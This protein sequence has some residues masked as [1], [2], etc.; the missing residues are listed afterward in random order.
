M[1]TLEHLI[2]ALSLA[3][4][5]ER[6]NIK[7][8]PFVGAIVVDEN[9]CIIG[10]GYHKMWGDKHAEVYAIEEAK[11]HTPDLTK[12]SLYVTLEPCSHHG[13]T[14]PCTDLIVQ[15]GI[16]TVFVGSLDPNPKVSGFELLKEKGVDIQLLEIKEALELNKVFFTNQKKQRPFVR[17]KIAATIA[18]K[19]ADYEANSKWITNIKSRAYVH[20]NIRTEVDAVLSTA[21]T[22]IEDKATLNIRN[23]N[24]PSI[25]LN[26][27][28]IDRTGS[29]LDVQH[30]T[31]PIFYQ[32]IHTKVFIVTAPNTIA[33][34]TPLPS[35][36][37]MIETPFNSNKEIDVSILGKQLLE[38]GLYSILV[39]AGEIF[40][41]FLLTKKWVD[42][43]DYFIGSKTL[44]DNQAVTESAVSKNIVLDQKLPLTL[45]RTI[46]FD[47]DIYLHYAIENF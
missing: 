10:T 34:N 19:M 38:K 17:I 27:V 5:A 3:K 35:N 16:K 31:L 11:S 30:A 18:G 8:N 15:S 45:L 22:V 36:I 29:I 14:P 40:S 24:T 43:L 26:A 6:K 32:R 9:N 21:K 44:L 47:N 20:S 25:E 12:S 7:G 39:E 33:P 1:T 4:K 28:I 2:E 42:E 37:E 46:P 41:T 13:K 23:E